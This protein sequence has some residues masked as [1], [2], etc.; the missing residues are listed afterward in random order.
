MITEEECRRRIDNATYELRR[1]IEVLIDERDELAFRAAIAEWAV[2]G[3]AAFNVRIAVHGNEV[4]QAGGDMARAVGIRA[5]AELLCR[6]GAAFTQHAEH[7]RLMREAPPHKRYIASPG[8]RPDPHDWPR[9]F[10]RATA[11]AGAVQEETGPRQ[12]DVTK[13]TT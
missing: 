7:A 11:S 4:M 2:A 8:K 5:G 6:A 3:V 9:P 13:E 1:R 12:S 10:H